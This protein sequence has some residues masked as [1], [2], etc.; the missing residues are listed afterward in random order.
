MSK[1]LIPFSVIICLLIPI[2]PAFSGD[3]KAPLK[4]YPALTG[5]EPLQ[6]APYYPTQP[7]TI[8]QSPGDTAGFTQYD[9]QTNGSVGNRIAIDS[10]GNVHVS[11]MKG[12]PYPSVRQVYYNCYTPTGWTNP[13]TGS[14][15]SSRN[16]DGFTSISVTSDN[17]AAIA[18]HNSTAESLSL[19]LDAYN[20]LGSFGYSFPANRVDTFYSVWPNLTVGQNGYIHMTSTTR[21]GGMN[22][23]NRSTDG[24]ITWTPPFR[25]DTTTSISTIITSSPV[26]NKVAIV[27]LHQN[28][29]SMVSTTYDVYYIQSLDGTTWDWANGKVNVTN[30]GPDRDSLSGGSDVDAVYDYNDNL[31]IVWNAHWLSGGFYY[32]SSWLYHYSPA[33]GIIT[34]II[35]SDSLWPSTGCA[36]GAWNW[37]FSK[38]SLGAQP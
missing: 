38:M 29:D 4:D 27:Y 19:A 10:L 9:F 35:K 13:G 22:L 15:V 30:Y 16:G 36:T 24:G 7:R 32:F 33:T 21:N 2:I 34:E 12:M 6:P 8:T 26:S 5:D 1:V 23:Y 28:P 20:C 14:P 18:Y 11:W 37:H 17:I 25:V 3:V 31:H